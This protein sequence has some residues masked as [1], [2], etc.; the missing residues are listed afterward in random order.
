MEIK[1]AKLTLIERGEIAPSE[2]EKRSMAD[3]LG[4]SYDVINNLSGRSE[5]AD[6]TPATEMLNDVVRNHSTTR[7]TTR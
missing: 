7:K 1:V 4:V 5:S 2:R 3:I 6:V